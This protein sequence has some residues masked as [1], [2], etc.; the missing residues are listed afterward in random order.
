M[1]KE[2]GNGIPNGLEECDNGHHNSD[3]MRDACRTNCRRARCGDGVED[4][5]EECD[6]GSANSNM[7]NACRLDCQLP[8]CGD[9]AVDAGEEC[10]FGTLNSDT[11]ADGCSTTCVWN[12]CRQV[13]VDSLVDYAKLLPEKCEKGFFTYV[14]SQTTPPCFEGV[15]WFVY[16]QFQTLSN[17]QLATI[18]SALRGAN[19]RPTQPLGT[20]AINYP[21]SDPQRCGNGI[22]EGNEECDDPAGNSNDQP[23]RC[24]TNCKLPF[25]GDGVVDCGEQCDGGQVCNSDCTFGNAQKG[26]RTVVNMFFKDL[27]PYN[28]FCCNSE[29]NPRTCSPCLSC[30]KQ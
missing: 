20:R 16:E 29:P 25:C 24:R 11:A 14:G 23:N 21:T 7:P 12:R 19:A 8:A 27:I 9:G 5:G 13:M 26:N 6:M 10:D 30:F 1:L 15:S 2:C 22:R 17:E 28:Y 18:R 3:T 4:L